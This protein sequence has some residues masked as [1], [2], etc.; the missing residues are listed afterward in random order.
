MKYFVFLLPSLFFF[1]SIFS[2]F[3]FLL[4]GHVVSVFPQRKKT[5]DQKVESRKQKGRE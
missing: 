1:F 3:L 2:L 5:E 4:S